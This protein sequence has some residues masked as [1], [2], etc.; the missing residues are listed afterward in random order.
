MQ[1]NDVLWLGL[2]DSY[3]VYNQLL[4]TMLASGDSA[5]NKAEVENPLLEVVG[6]VGIITI[7]GSLINGSSGWMLR[8]G[9]T[10]Y[11][12]IRAALV[13]ALQHSEVGSIMLNISS[14]GG[15]AEGPHDLAM[16]IRR[17][18][19]VKPVVTY[20]GS[21]MHSAALW[22]GASARRIFASETAQMGS[23]GTIIV[24]KDYSEAYKAENI[25][26]TVIRAGAK[27]ALVNGYEPLTK[28][29]KT[30]LENK[31]KFMYD[32]F[33]GSVAKDRNMPEDVADEKYGQ[34]VEL[35]ASQAKDAGLIDEV[36]SYD[37]AY[38]YTQKL[39]EK[40]MDPNRQPQQA[41]TRFGTGMAASATNVSQI[42]TQAALQQLLSAHNSPTFE[43]NTMPQ[44]LSDVQ[45]AAMAAGVVLAD[46]AAAAPT[47]PTAPAAAGAGAPAVQADAGAGAA[48]A[49][50]A[51]APAAAP[52]VQADNGMT[53]VL[54]SLSASQ[55]EV[56]RLTAE[57]ATMK[58]SIEA[59]TKTN[60]A[61]VG[62]ARAAVTSMGLHFG[63]SAE[64][65]ASM[66][67]ETVASEYARIV[68]LF[69]EKFK[70][71]GV[72]ATSAPADESKSEGTNALPLAFRVATNAK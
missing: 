42:S 13:E 35:F 65:V 61:L 30:D 19:K 29:A 49:A 16:L 43:G 47:A 18:D 32:L 6:N 66:S 27:K 23:L 58:A 24:H 48:P 64:A 54:A 26:V 7:N 69:K 50:A 15:A 40:R 28:D 68:P 33:L 8:Y 20:T 71:G 22:V 9:V 36:G 10:G 44:P 56:G 70:A 52:A 17:I 1:K 14:G 34:G 63:L 41:R 11:D 4:V 59:A 45:I 38:A 51:A 53:A 57:V 46:A 67:A 12:D 2:A 60:E 5:F 55:A 21:H 62:I 3:K 72:A 37:D 39:A 25:K 31:A